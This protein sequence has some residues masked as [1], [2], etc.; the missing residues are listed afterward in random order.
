MGNQQPVIVV[1]VA[2]GVSAGYDARVVLESVSLSIGPGELVAL[3]GPNGSGKSTLLKVLAGL[4]EARGGQA[5]VLAGEPGRQPRRV[6]Y[7]PQAEAVDW[8]FPV[9]VLDV[10]LMGRTPRVGWLR[11]PG[12]ADRAIAQEAL[13]RVGMA[14][15]RDR[16]IGALSGGQRRR[17]FL[18]RALTTEPDLYLLDE[19]VT[20]VDPAT[21]EDLMAL[22]EAECQ[23]G[24]SVL[25]S[26]H[27][28]AGVLSHF[29]RVIC[30][31]RSVVAD[32]P[33]AILQDA[34]VLRATYGGHLVEVIGGRALLVDDP[35]HAPSYVAGQE[36]RRG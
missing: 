10:A 24:K 27:D 21:E 20:G 4:L 34:E 18:A 6:A 28:L 29:K 22:L 26:T 35:H 17:V 14:E 13:R 36:R 2:S 15:L 3:V 11:G 9:T 31:N 33:A 19:P 7:L 5:L 16:Q 12:R 8:T 25:A 32:G 30:L 1:I 23:T